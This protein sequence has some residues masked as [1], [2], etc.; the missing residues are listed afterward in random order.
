HGGSDLLFHF[1]GR[2]FGEGGP[3]V[4]HNVESV[5]VANHAQP[6]NVIG[7]VEQVRAMR[8]GE[9]EMLMSV[10][11]VVVEGYVFSLLFK[12]ELSRRRETSWQRGLAV[13]LMRNSPRFQ[14]GLRVNA[15]GLRESRVNRERRRSGLPA[16][17]VG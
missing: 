13:K 2:I 10:L 9:H 15:G 1:R 8:G 7:R 6:N 4:L 16:R 5:S 17:L 14:H 11:G 12:L 3:E